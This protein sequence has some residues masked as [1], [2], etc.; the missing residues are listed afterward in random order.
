MR[1]TTILTSIKE[2]LSHRQGP[3]AFTMRGR[4]TNATSTE[5]FIDG[6][7]GRRIVPS[8]DSTVVLFIRGVFHYSNGG[9]SFTDSTHLFRVSPLGVI[10]QLDSDG[11]TAGVQGVEAA[12]TV[13]S[14]SGAV[15]PKLSAMS[16]GTANGFTLNIVA[17][18]ATS[19]S[20]IAL[21]ANG[22]ASV[23]ADW[24]FDIKYIEA[25]P[26]G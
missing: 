8:S 15:V 25:G 18:T 16:L 20:Y 4:T 1:F 3:G 9:S 24:E 5:L 23:N 2:A 21:F 17:A 10:T 7:P 14:P 12:A 11:T 26:R 13:L 6:Q 19:P 22:V